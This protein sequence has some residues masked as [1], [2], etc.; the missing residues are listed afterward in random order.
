MPQKG[1]AMK[2]DLSTMDFISG[3]DPTSVNELKGFIFPED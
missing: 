1:L 3:D 2:L